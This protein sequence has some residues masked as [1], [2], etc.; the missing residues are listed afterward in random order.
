MLASPRDAP[1]LQSD[2]LKVG[3]HGS[4]SSTTPAFLDAVHPE[5]AVVSAGRHNL[6]G[7]PRYP[8]L[9]RLGQEGA[10]VARTDLDGAQSFL[11]NG[12][13]VVMTAP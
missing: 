11:L 7:H 5:W 4:L 6:F 13:T 9:L 12:Q 2:L 3:H 8:I 1:L 10:R